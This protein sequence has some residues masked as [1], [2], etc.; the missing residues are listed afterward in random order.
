MNAPHWLK[1]RHQIA[2]NVSAY[3]PPALGGYLTNVTF[4]LDGRPTPSTTVTSQLYQQSIFCPII[5]GD[6][7]VQKRFFDAMLQGCIPLVPYF[8][9]SIEGD[10]YP[11]FFQWNGRP[12][13]RQTYPWSKGTFRGDPQ[14]GIDYMDLVLPFDGFA[15]E[16]SIQ[17]VVR[18]TL[19]NTTHLRQLRRT[20]MTYA[21]LFTFG[22]DENLQQSMDGFSAT[23]V[24][25]R[26]YLYTLDDGRPSPI[27]I[28]QFR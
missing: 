10:T 9:K 21:P 28:P 14:A 13:I 4:H 3:I 24:A 5:S 17:D 7:A 26:H 2:Q 19:F 6:D 12:S 22:L 23:F 11:T 8:P 16:S 1:M 15:P 25:I 20:L 27:Q 18:E